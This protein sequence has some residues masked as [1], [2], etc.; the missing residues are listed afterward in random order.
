MVT[1]TAHGPQLRLT[2]R[3]RVVVLMF[4]VL[5]ASLCSAVLFT[6]ASRAESPAGPSRTTVVQPHDT[7]WQIASR[8]SPDL[9]PYAAVAEIRRLNGLSG[10]VVH[11]GQ[12]L[13][14]PPRDRCGRG[15][16]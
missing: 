11:P 14:I 12:T 3:G 9:E 10:S 1:S 16:R 2:R 15:A 7:L 5:L 4:F 6:T 8:T 13:V